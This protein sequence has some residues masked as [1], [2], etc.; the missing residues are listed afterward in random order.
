MSRFTGKK[1]VVTGGT[2]GMGLGIVQGLIDGGAEVVLTGRSEAKVESARGLLTSPA[3]HVVRSDATSAADIE[4]L[5]TLVADTLGQ[6]DAV[7]VNHGVAEF[8]TLDN[9]TE[10]S[11][12]KQFAVNTKGAVFTV[13]RLAPLVRD[14]GSFTFTTVAND[15]IFPGLTAYSGSK[16]GLQAITKVLAAEFLPRRIRVNSVAPGYIKTPSMGVPGLSDAERA[17]FEA[18]GD[19]SPLGRLGSIE[20]VAAAALF[21]GFDATYTT[22]AELPVDGGFAQG[23]ASA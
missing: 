11:F 3:A 15:L 18:E 22:A 9:L 17:A 20:E 16:E 23:I 14:G 21:L 10:E 8:Q 5:G 2:H 12:D 4:A 7:F 6:V 1:A 13:K 19:Q